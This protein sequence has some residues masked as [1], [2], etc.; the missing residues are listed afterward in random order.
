MQTTREGEPSPA[1]GGR[2][3][4]PLDRLRHMCRAAVESFAA[5]LKANVLLRPFRRREATGEIPTNKTFHE[6]MAA[7]NSAQPVEA[8]QSSHSCG[9]TGLVLV[10]TAAVVV[11]SGA[12]VM[13]ILN[14][15]VSG[16]LITTGAYETTASQWPDGSVLSLEVESAVRVNV[17]EQQRSARVV[18]GVVT[19]KVPNL[20]LPFMVET[21]LAR[22]HVPA[23]ALFRVAVSAVS[24]D[25]DVLQGTVWIYEQG[26]KGAAQARRL[27]AGETYHVSAHAMA[28]LAAACRDRV[29]VRIDG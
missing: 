2:G 24:A 16:R 6:L 22:V 15:S 26:V 5:C 20:T 21:P 3:W 28:S 9:A 27:E 12:L 11:S 1:S 10:A 19:F 23:Q 14:T 13:F 25:V 4:C 7:L 17:T 29:C 18:R 8:M